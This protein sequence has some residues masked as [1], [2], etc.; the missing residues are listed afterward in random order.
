M[1]NRKIKETGSDIVIL[2]H[3]HKKTSKP[4]APLRRYLERWDGYEIEKKYK[5]RGK[6]TAY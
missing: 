3:L 6:E 5:K 1:E 4:V 2:H